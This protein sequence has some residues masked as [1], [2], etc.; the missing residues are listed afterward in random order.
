MKKNT[1][2]NEI[3]G[4]RYK[5]WTVVKFHKI[6]SHNDARFICKC[7]LCKQEYSVKGYTLRN[8]SSTKCKKCAGK[9]VVQKYGD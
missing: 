3:P 1:Y 9:R 7:E 2:I 5:H 6:D 4:T 8:G